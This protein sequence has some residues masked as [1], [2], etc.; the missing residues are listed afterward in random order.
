MGPRQYHGGDPGPTRGLSLTQFVGSNWTIY[1]GAG[2]DIP[3]YERKPMRA[4]VPS[5]NGLFLLPPQ[6]H[7]RAD[8]RRA[9]TRPVPL[10]ISM[11][12]RSCSGPSVVR[13]DRSGPSRT[14]SM[15]ALPVA[16]SPLAA[17][18]TSWCEPSQNGLFFDAPQR[19]SVT[20]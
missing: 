19:Q 15:S 13:R 20:R 3:S 8:S 6:R 18:L 7:S 10:M 5:Q 12:P 9:T 14:G 16:G 1:E 17:K 2:L 4:W 11:L